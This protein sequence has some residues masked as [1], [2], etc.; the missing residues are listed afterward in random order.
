MVL[1]RILFIQWANKG[2]K[3]ERMSKR[4]KEQNEREKESTENN[5]KGWKE[6]KICP[7]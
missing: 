5:D 1:E 2:K 3:N 7:V 4:M 6:R